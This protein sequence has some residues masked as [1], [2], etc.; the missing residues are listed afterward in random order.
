MDT[1]ERRR[2]KES[3]RLRFEPFVRDQIA[4]C[5][6]ILGSEPDRTRPERLEEIRRRIKEKAGEYW[7][8]M[9]DPISKEQFDVAMQVLDEIF[10]DVMRT[11]VH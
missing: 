6:R 4:V 3:Y 5:E 10:A 1:A 9:D 2:R 7:G 11:A 8:I